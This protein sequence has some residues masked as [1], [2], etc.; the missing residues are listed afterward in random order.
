MQNTRERILYDIRSVLAARGVCEMEASFAKFIDRYPS[1]TYSKG[2]TILLKDHKPRAVYVIESGIVRAY[3]ITGDGAERLVAI[4]AKGEDI[5]TGFGSGL[6]D[7]A[8]YFYEAY[9]NC[10]I[11]LV[12]REQFERHLRTNPEILYQRHVRVEALLL[13]TFSHVNALEQPKAGDKI[14]FTLFYMA[15]HLGVRLRPHKT[16]LKFSVTQQEIADSLGITRETAG[17]ELK[18]LELKRILSHSRKSY[19]LYMER[20]RRYL[21]ERS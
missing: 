19:V 6:S 4:H 14:A 7:T 18:K 20:L 21:D 9:T 10:R 2:Q 15:N 1:E 8:S 17:S 5:P 16:Q 12:P 3:M 11:R 13:A